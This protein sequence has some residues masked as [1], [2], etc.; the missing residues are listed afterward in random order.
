M[1]ACEQ[2]THCVIKDVECSC[3]AWNKLWDF[4]LGW[5]FSLLDGCVDRHCELINGFSIHDLASAARVN[6]MFSAVSV[7]FL[8]YSAKSS[9]TS[10]MSCSVVVSIS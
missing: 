10:V 3:D 1:Y 5:N 8:K 7:T 4:G 2:F 6:W 9:T